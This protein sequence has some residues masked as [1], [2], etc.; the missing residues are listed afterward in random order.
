MLI[1]KLKLGRQ[2]KIVAQKSVFYFKLSKK[3]LY[4]L[5]QV[6]PRYKRRNRPILNGSETWIPIPFVFWERAW[7]N[8][9]LSL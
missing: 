1:G 4:L 2:N 5:F 3:M 6:A 8:Q 7:T 9:I